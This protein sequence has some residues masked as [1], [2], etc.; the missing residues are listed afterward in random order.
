[1][2]NR[3]WHR[4]YKRHHLRRHYFHQQNWEPKR[5]LNIPIKGILKWLVVIILIINY[6]QILGLLNNLD[7]KPK[8]VL[9]KVTFV[10]IRNETEIEMKIYELTNSERIK[11]GKHSLIY[12]PELSRLAK[13]WSEKMI[14]ENFFEHSNY[15]IGENIGEVP[16]S[17]IPL[18]IITEGCIITLTNNQIASCHVNSWVGS[19]GHYQNMIDSSYSQI[20]V[21]ISCDLMTC[22]ATQMFS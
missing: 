12:N 15:N 21:G 11:V 18:F 10:P 19:L 8:G 7:G 17:V 1:M 20:G 4:R 13:G 2:K 5:R 9:S 6:S 22:R 3:N 16:I 14:N